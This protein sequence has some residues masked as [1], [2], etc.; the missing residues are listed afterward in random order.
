M[1]LAVKVIWL[2]LWTVCIAEDCKGPPP[3]KATEILSGSWNDQ[4]Y[5]AGTQAF[6][7]CRPGYRTLG[8]IVMECRKGEWVSLYPSRTCRKKP[9][10]HPGDIAFGS[11]QLTVGNEFEFGAKVVYTCNEGYQM[12]G[13]VNYRECEADGWT[14][15][16]PLCEVIKCLPVTAPENG[17]IINDLME[18]DQ[19][20]SFGQVVQ[21]EC[22]SGFKLSGRKEIHCS[23]NGAWSEDPPKCVEISCESPEIRNG[24]S[25]SQKKT[26]RENERLQYKCHLGFVYRE[27]GDAICTASGW[28]PSPFCEAVSVMINYIV[29]LIIL[30]FF[31]LEIECRIPEIEQ[32]LIAYPNQ[33]KYRVGDV[34]KFSCRQR[35]IRVGPDSVQCYPFGWSPDVPVCKAEVSTCGPPPELPNGDIEKTRETEYTHGDQVEFHCKPGFLMKGPKKIQCVDGTW[36]TLPI[37]IEEK[38][39]CGDIPELDHGY[40]QPPDPPYRHG[41]SVEFSCRET[42]TMIGHGT[43]TCVKG[44]WTQLPSCV[45]TDQLE[46]CKI[47]K[48]TVNEANLPNKLEYDHNQNISYKCRGK[49]E[50]KHSVCIN[51]RWDPEVTCRGVQP[52]QLCPPPPQIPN[53]QDMKTTV[54][55]QDGEKVSVLCQEGY[56]IQEAEEVVCKDGKWQSL[57]RCA[58]KISCSQLPEIKNGTLT[59]PSS[60]EKIKKMNEPSS[61][62]HGTKLNYSCD[63]GFKKLKEDEITCYMG[64]WSFPQCVGEDMEN[65]NSALV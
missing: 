19:E 14:N 23:D 20:Y 48:S 11:F 57:P 39:T 54:N 31:S 22:N 7:K 41:D 33:E 15:E 26:F 53:A 38:S 63:E 2:M 34:L 62:P 12:L 25:L 6:Y 8:T 45:A 30:P 36:T 3:R 10:G 61:Y 17:R 43:V 18:P 1:R 49:A 37:C 21:F 4:T 5:S 52:V 42:F 40:V 56:L 29:S 16:V 65:S 51:G 58:E 13:E 47:S 28:S 35:F 27:R 64:K 24:F 32:N 55:Y 9:C 60:S 46:K 50:S 59:L 44:T